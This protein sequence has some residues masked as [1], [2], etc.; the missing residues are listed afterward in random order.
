MPQFRVI[1]LA[2]AKER[3]TEHTSENPFVG[4]LQAMLARDIEN[5]AEHGQGLTFQID[6]E[7]SDSIKGTKTQITQAATQL[8]IRV[9]HVEGDGHSII[10][11]IA[12]DDEKSV[13]DRALK[14]QAKRAAAKAAAAATEA[15]IET[16]TEPQQE[17]E[18][19]SPR[20]GKRGRRAA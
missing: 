15:A 6:L 1:S 7:E 19:A 18:Q 12:A 10:V 14:S 2:E 9:N 5:R 17:E 20:R 13:T 11:W 4:H 3:D 8:G 16:A